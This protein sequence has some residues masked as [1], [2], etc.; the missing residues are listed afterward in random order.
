MATVEQKQLQQ[1]KELVSGLKYIECFVSR[2]YLEN[3]SVYPVEAPVVQGDGWGSLR[4]VKLHR[5]IFDEQENTNDKLVSVYGAL[6]SIHASVFLILDSDGSGVDFYAGTRC[7]DQASTAGL[8]L[9]KGLQGNFPGSSLTSLRREEIAR[10]MQTAFAAGQGRNIAAVTMVPALRDEDRDRFVQGIEK[11]V[12]TLSGQRYTALLLAE[13]MPQALVDQ[14]RRGLEEMYTTVT[15]LSKTSLAYGDN[16]STAVADGIFSSFSDSVNSSVTNS[17]SES[18]S[19]SFSESDSYGTNW[20]VSSDGFSTGSSS[21]HGTTSTSGTSTSWSKAMSTGTAKTSSSG[22]NHTTTNTLG[23]SRTFTINQENKSATDM[24]DRIQQ[25]L[26]RLKESEAF[27]LWSCGAYFIAEDPQ[28]CMVAASSFRALLAGDKTQVEN[29]FINLWRSGSSRQAAQVFNCLQHAQHPRIKLPP[30]SAFSAQTVTPS[31]LVSGKELPLFLGMPQ[32]SVPGLVVDYIASFGR[33]IFCPDERPGEKKIRI[34]QVLHKGVTQATPVNLALE[35]LRSHCFITGST[36]S[37]KS[38][39]TYCL[40][41]QLLQNQIRFL[42]VEPAK[43]EY[44]YQFGGL[45]GINIFWTNPEQ[46][47]MLR[48]NPFSF[49]RGIHVLEHLD[50]LIE[51]F[52]ACWPLYSAM[53]AI[54]KDAVERSYVQCGWDLVSS[55]RFENG[56]PEFPDFSVLTDQLVRTIQ[57]SSYSAQSKGDYTGAL[58]TRVGALT[59]GLMG[60]IFCGGY[61]IADEVLFDQ[62]TIVDLSRVGAAE[63]KSLI[64]GILVMK[65]NEHRMARADSENAALRH[66]T[67]LEEAHNLLKRC[68]GAQSQDSA[69]VQGKSV[70]MLSSSI[71]EMRTYGEGF[72]IV[73]QSPSAV[74]ISAIKNTNTKIVM[75]LPEQSDFEAIGHSFALQDDQIREISRLGRGQA[76][77]SQQGWLEPVLTLVDACQSGHYLR[78]AADDPATR[79]RLN[80]KLA[81][82]LV[83]QMQDELYQPAILENLVRR[84][85]LNPFK[86]QDY[87]AL[88]RHF[89]P[90]IEQDPKKARRLCDTCLVELLGCR[91]LF[92]T[93]PL[94]F[95]QPHS[96]DF[97]DED[98]K[99]LNRWRSEMLQ[100]LPSYA[101][102]EDDA[103]ARILLLRLALYQAVVIRDPHYIK[104]IRA[105]KKG[106]IR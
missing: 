7:A 81:I 88:L 80:G 90:Q 32:R 2:S 91:G 20:G 78:S 43:G 3:L 4:L 19:N 64:M 46:F 54:L 66:V 42:V 50:R 1:E 49:P 18:V 98:A 25:Q 97:T 12:D 53:P 47:R 26:D 94:R 55:R 62:N 36:G 79:R 58:V 33:D 77:I 6:Q 23:E 40:L 39:T 16:I 9:E 102:F 52:N 37:G 106:L 87:T 65:L 95:A 13:A 34:G 27:G 41:E 59:K 10:K 28:V 30:V 75:R 35:M 57:E 38:N 48:L 86:Q 82:R 14:R 22:E 93:F 103:E 5:L 60:Q 51:I 104:Y 67:V 44:K 21:S 56:G 105:K 72:V 61:E 74:D 71:A 68:G 100:A 29:A 69:N 45:P 84:S 101:E 85:G 89:M 17:N 83:E 92:Q 76:I 96:E 73:D 99:T 11:L 63:T 31:A 8:L 70:E 24:L 15:P